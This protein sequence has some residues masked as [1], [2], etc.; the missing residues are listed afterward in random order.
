MS[1]ENVEI[2][3]AMWDAFLRG[4]AEGALAL[5]HPAVVWDGRN[6][7]DGRVAHGVGEVI[8]HVSR[9]AEI[10]EDWTVDV[11]QVIDAGGDQVLLLMR[12]RGTGRSGMAM[13]ERHAEVYTVRDGKV[14]GRIGYSDPAEALEAAGLSE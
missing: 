13:D 1:R 10:W 9:W 11:E 3:R 4:D 5:F 8:N 12:E 6:L 14:V 2:V 7:P